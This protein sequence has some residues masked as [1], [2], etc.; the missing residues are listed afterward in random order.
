MNPMPLPRSTVQ[1]ATQPQ[2]CNC[3]KLFDPKKGKK[4]CS[5]KCKKAKWDKSHVQT[6]WSDDRKTKLIVITK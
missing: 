3:G 1:N 2:C 5:T 6:F 4:Y